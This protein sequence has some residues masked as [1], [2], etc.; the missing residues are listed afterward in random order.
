MNLLLISDVIALFLSFSLAWTRWR[1]FSSSI[2][3]DE[4][5]KVLM[6]RRETRRRGRRI[7]LARNGAA[8]ISLSSSLPLFEAAQSSSA[9]N[10]RRERGHWWLEFSRRNG[11]KRERER[12]TFIPTHNGIYASIFGV[13]RGPLSFS[14]GVEEREEVKEE[15]ESREEEESWSSSSTSLKLEDH[16][17][18][19]RLSEETY[20]IHKQ[21][22]KESERER[23]A[24]A[25]R[26]AFYITG[27]SLQNLD[28]LFVVVWVVSLVT[29]G[30]INFC[31]LKK[32]QLLC[33][34]IKN[35]LEIPTFNFIHKMELITC[36]LN[37]FS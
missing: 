24:R 7:A 1:C 29:F 30:A 33:F 32:T 19:W 2:G 27:F 26:T 11:W 17:P 9:R 6:E 12:E 23:E 20:K 4:A 16:L 25:N 21:R 34:K 13:V 18:F 36:K 31:C 35:N 5:S 3:D 15:L 14:P 28:P 22:E 10:G 8:M 37:Y